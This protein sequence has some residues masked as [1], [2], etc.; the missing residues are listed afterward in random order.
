MKDNIKA[1]RKNNPDRC[2]AGA[3]LREHASCGIRTLI[4][5]SYLEGLLVGST[6]CSICGCELN[7]ELGTGYSSNSPSMDR[8][9]NEDEIRYDNIWIVCRKCNSTKSDRT[10]KEFYDY[11]KSITEKFKSTYEGE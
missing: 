9:D 5:T 2:R 3:I 6:H 1:W 11:C 10:M 4:P 8:I 7:H